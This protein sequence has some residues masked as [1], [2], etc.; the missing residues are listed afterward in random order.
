MNSRSESRKVSLSPNNPLDER[1]SQQHKVDSWPESNR[2]KKETF[3]GRKCTPLL[4][5]YSDLI[6]SNFSAKM[7]KAQRHA[8][9]SF[10]VVV[11]FSDLPSG[12]T[13]FRSDWSCSKLTEITRRNR[14]VCFPWVCLGESVHR[15]VSQRNLNEPDVR[16]SR[17]RENGTDV[18]A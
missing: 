7:S 5:V 3:I 2:A 6:L 1:P 4:V 16:C 14:T 17:N 9:S 13:N 8:M 10:G 15:Q 12:K 18:C 11:V